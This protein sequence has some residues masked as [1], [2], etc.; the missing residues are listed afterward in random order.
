MVQAPESQISRSALRS[1]FRYMQHEQ[2][3]KWLQDI[4]AGHFTLERIEPDQV[5]VSS[6]ESEDGSDEE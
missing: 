5:D 2:R 1:G 6:D 3:V 4:K